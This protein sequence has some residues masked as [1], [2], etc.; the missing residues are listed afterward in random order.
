MPRLL[1]LAAQPGRLP[2]S[3]APM[4]ARKRK[5]PPDGDAGADAREAKSARI[6]HR[7]PFVMRLWTRVLEGVAKFLYVIK[8]AHFYNYAKIYMIGGAGPLGSERI[9]GLSGRWGWSDD[10]V[11][12]SAIR[13]DSD[14]F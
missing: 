13:S 10:T 5:A 14:G 4:E 3:G 2:N 7:R 1:W 9:L 12:S 8:K 6:R 11:G